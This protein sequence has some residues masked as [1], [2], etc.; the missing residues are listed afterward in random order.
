[1]PIAVRVVSEEAFKTWLEGA[2]KKFAR[3]DATPITVGQS[4]AR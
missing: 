1:M 3:E 2:R 4:A